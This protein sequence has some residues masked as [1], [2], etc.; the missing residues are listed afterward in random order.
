MDT[1]LIALAGNLGGLVIAVVILYK[2]LRVTSSM[3]V[4]TSQ[5]VAA[6]GAAAAASAVSA[7]SAAEARFDKL[8][9]MFHQEMAA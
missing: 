5:A 6:A 7:A 4:A 9:V 3:A 2:M 1:V 8:L